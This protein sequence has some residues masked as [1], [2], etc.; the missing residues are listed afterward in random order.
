MKQNQATRGAY[1]IQV[2]AT[3]PRDF[4]HRLPV[5]ALL[6]TDPPGGGATMV[7]MTLLEG[8]GHEWS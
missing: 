3:R 5:L 1:P 7:L 8:I 6:R 2:E 4:V